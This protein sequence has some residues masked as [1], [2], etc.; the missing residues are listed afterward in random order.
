[1]SGKHII[2]L[3]QS[4]QGTKA[5][6]MDMNG[7]IVGRAFKAHEQIIS[8]EGWVSH[9]AE[10]IYR[11]CITVI[12]ELVKSSGA[13]KRDIAAIGITNQRET[14]AAWNRETGC[15]VGQAIVWQCDRAKEI[16]DGIESE[17]FKDYVRHSTGIPLSPYFPA[18][19]AAWILRHRD[20][21]AGLAAE[22]KLCIGTVDSWLV[23][24]FTGGEV[25]KTDYS[26]ASRTQ[27]FNLHSLSWDEK[28]CAELNI[29]IDALPE[30]ENSDG[31]FGCTT[32]EGYFDEP[33][34]IRAVMG[35]SHAALFGQGCVRPG[36]AKATYGTGSSVM[37]NI[38][39]QFR[40]SCS[41]LVTSLAWGRGGTVDYVL[42]GNI[43]Y[44]GATITWLQKDLGLFE[45]SAETEAMAFA[46]NPEDSC[47]LVP[48]FSGLGA[49][50]W[51]HDARAVI[52]GMS[53]TTGKN[54]LVKA[55]LECIAYQ[56]TDIAQAMAQDAGIALAEL[57]ADGGPT[58][59]AYLMQFQS[60]MSGAR[61][62]VPESQEL[63]AMGTAYMAGMG[64]GLYGEDIL[65]TR[66]LKCEYLPKMDDETKAK[67]YSGWRAA[68][69]KA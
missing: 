1:M 16:V 9:D 65:N 34:P 52:A 8:A 61:I 47:Y 11:S 56:V 35:D 55:G 32:A 2:G 13:D 22:G 58:A 67:K 40:E 68:V 25:F 38:G 4:T 12:K 64:V 27:L 5:I 10:E 17:A 43:N 15:A 3:D 6:L 42:E 23:Y 54:E 18:A 29:D 69:E 19:K 26:N 60:D 48:A 66:R 63:S 30:V 57:R 7:T 41:G 14:T 33:I 44:A 28:I 50:Y 51:R 53:R 59:N 49:P 39:S 24:K 21:A 62:C 45:T 36:M 31:N 37:M 20:T 46:A